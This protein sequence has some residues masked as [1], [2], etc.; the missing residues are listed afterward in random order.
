MK[1][2]PLRAGFGM[3]EG[4]IVVL[5][6]WGLTYEQAARGQTGLIE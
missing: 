1:C 3:V 5:G 6:G 2:E 4:Q